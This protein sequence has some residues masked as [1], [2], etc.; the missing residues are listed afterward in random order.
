MCVCL[1][2]QVFMCTYNFM[3]HVFVNE[4]FFCSMK[5]PNLTYL[6]VLTAVDLSCLTVNTSYMC[7]VGAYKWLAFSDLCPLDIDLYWSLFSKHWFFPASELINGSTWSDWESNTGVLHIIAQCILFFLSRFLS[8]NF[9]LS[10]TVFL[11]FSFLSFIPA[12]FLSVIHCFPFS[13]TLSNSELRL[14]YLFLLKVIEFQ[15]QLIWDQSSLLLVSA[16]DLSKL[17]PEQSG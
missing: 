17:P 8:L 6:K 3:L 12:P 15:L 14:D 9:F 1:F 4:C 2:T 11:C 13:F 5:N 10:L 16:T 7:I